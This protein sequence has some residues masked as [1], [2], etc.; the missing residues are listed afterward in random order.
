RGLAAD[1]A[2]GREFWI[3]RRAAATDRGLRVAAGAGVEVEARPQA[4][5]GSAGDGLHFLKAGEPV[6]EELGDA[7]RGVVG[8]RGERQRAGRGR[9]ALTIDGT[10][11]DAGVR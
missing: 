2:G 8:D 1:A 9:A 10:G 4:V 3:A 5:V 7:R 6:L 11:P